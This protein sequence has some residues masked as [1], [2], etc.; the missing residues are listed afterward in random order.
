MRL[1]EL[2]K[3]TESKTADEIY[4]EALEKYHYFKDITSKYPKYNTTQSAEAATAIMKKINDDFFMGELEPGHNSMYSKLY[5]KVL[6][7]LT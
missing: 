1:T 2:L 5:D 6:A 3:L 4:K 7:G